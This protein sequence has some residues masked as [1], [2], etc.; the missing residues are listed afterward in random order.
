MLSPTFPRWPQVAMV[1]CPICHSLASLSRFGGPILGIGRANSLNVAESRCVF[2]AFAHLSRGLFRTHLCLSEIKS[3]HIGDAIRPGPDGRICAQPVVVSETYIP[4]VAATL[5]GMSGNRCS[6]QKIPCS[7]KKI[8]CY[9][10][11]NS[12]FRCVGRTQST[13][14]GAWPGDPRVPALG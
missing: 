11:K 4:R 5:I 8:P 2:H 9:G 10:R 3:A 14:G 12:L 13:L 7:S 1:I 6:D